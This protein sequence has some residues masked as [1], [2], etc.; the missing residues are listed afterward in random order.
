MQTNIQNVINEDTRRKNAK[1]EI[2]NAI[3]QRAYNLYMGNKSEE[4]II[5]GAFSF[6]KIALQDGKVT[7]EEVEKE[8]A[9]VLNLST[10]NNKTR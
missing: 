2:L 3:R 10:K 9:K 4:E 7:K 5:S 8:I 1:G 6:A